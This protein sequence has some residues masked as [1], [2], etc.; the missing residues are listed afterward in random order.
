M[1]S[2]SLI[3]KIVIVWV[4]G[5]VSSLLLLLS[6]EIISPPSELQ[7]VPPIL[8]FQKVLKTCFVSRPGVNV[9]GG[10]CPIFILAVLVQAA[11]FTF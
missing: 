11:L 10:N 3:L 1:C 2:R 4:K 7:R 6:F 9:S 8:G 5:S